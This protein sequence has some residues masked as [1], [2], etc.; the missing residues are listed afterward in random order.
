MAT[1]LGFTK[2]EIIRFLDS[3][4]APTPTD[5]LHPA[6]WWNE[7]FGLKIRSAFDQT[8]ADIKMHIANA[9]EE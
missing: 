4:E 1:R 7:N 8:M 6:H 3:I 2:A 5:K 9:R